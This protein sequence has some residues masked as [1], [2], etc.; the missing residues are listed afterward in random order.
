MLL[1]ALPVLAA[2][3]TMLLFDR[4]FNTSFF[5]PIGGGDVVLYQHLFWFFGHPEVYILIIPS[6]GI[7]SHVVSTFS[8][9]KIFGH[10]SMIGAMI[11]IAVVGFLVWAHHMYTSGIDVNTRAYFT[12]ATMVIAIPTGIKVFNWLATMWGGIIQL[13]TP[14]YFALGFILLFTIG[15]I[16]GVILSNAGIDVALHDTYYV[17]AHFH[18]V[19]SM[20]AVFGIFSGFY[21]WIGKITGYQYSEYLGKI[22]FWIMFIGANLTFF[23]MHLLGIAGMP[24]RIPDYPDIYSSFNLIS[25]IGSIFSFFGIIFWIFLIYKMFMD[26]QPCPKNPWLTVNSLWIVEKKIFLL[27]KLVSNIYKGKGTKFTIYDFI[28]H[29][30]KFNFFIRSHHFKVNSLEWTLSSPMKLHTFVSPPKIITS[31]YSYLYYRHGSNLSTKTMITP[32]FLS[33]AFAVEP[34]CSFILNGVSPYIY[35]RKNATKK[36]TCNL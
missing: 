34:R 11:V 8:Q 28:H 29:L 19:L 33:T 27:S 36:N 21:Y 23:P 14:L 32:Y 6:F 7:I 26:K 22:H 25:S 15:G 20:G 18:Y 2:A 5:D 12:A 1:L 24:R 16:T 17:V 9:K 4:N 35:V 13:K 3:I 10:V 30:Y 31:N